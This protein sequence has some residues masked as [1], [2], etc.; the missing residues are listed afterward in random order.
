MDYAVSCRKMR[1]LGGDCYD[2]CC[3]PKGRLIMLVGDTSAKDMAAALTITGV[4]GV[5]L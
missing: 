2:L 3:Q 5:L 1:A 4:Q